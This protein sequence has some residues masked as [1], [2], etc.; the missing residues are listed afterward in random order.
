MPRP[1]KAAPSYL[2]HKASG[3]AR[4]VWTD[5]DGHHHDKLLPGEYGSEESR[6]AFARMILERQVS[7]AAIAGV[8]KPVTLTVSELL[9]RYLTHATMYY[10]STDGKPSSALVETRLVIRALRTLYEATLAAEFGPLKL[11]AVQQSWVAANLS[12]GECNKRLGIAKRIFKWAVAE[13]LVP[14]SVYHA[15]ATVGGLQKGRSSAPD[16]APVGP[17]EDAVVDA[18]LMHLNRHLR[19]LIEVQRLTGM[20]PGEVTRL[21]M[22]E[23]DSSGAVWMFRPARHKNAHRGQS[24]TVAIGKRAQEI[25]VTFQTDDP[26]EYLFSPRKAVAEMN[27]ARSAA[28]KAKKY[29]SE[30]RRLAVKKKHHRYNDRY[31]TVRYGIAVNR[32]A[33]KAFQPPPPLALR[34]G[35]TRK[36]WQA[37]LTPTQR[38]ELKAWQEAHRWQPNQLRH[39]FATRVRK[40]FG[41]DGAQV[42]LGHAS[43]DVTQVYAARDEAAAVGI[44]SKIG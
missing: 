26:T 39:S 41:L 1:K 17:V 28:R 40:E 34:K 33:D 31:T 16:F 44:A 29:P 9:V 13:E 6:Q 8:P 21:R 43:A 38:D 27:A 18:T 30:V 24:R 22:S 12:R 42:A 14:P 4:F 23:I 32:A 25:I 11:R 37:R 20:R 10:S 5:P 2:K 7:P 19:G 36:E 35:E 15:L 3:R